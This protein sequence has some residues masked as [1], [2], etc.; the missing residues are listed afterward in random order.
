MK[1]RAELQR[2]RRMDDHPSTIHRDTIGTKDSLVCKTVDTEERERE[3]RAQ[4]YGGRRATMKGNEYE[5]RGGR[6]QAALLEKTK[7]QV[8]TWQIMSV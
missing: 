7:T 3:K 6:S 4:V 1:G 5:G 8:H 2:V